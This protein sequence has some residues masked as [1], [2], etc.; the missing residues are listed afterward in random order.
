M[1]DTTLWNDTIV[2]FVQ[3]AAMS[4]PPPLTGLRVLEFA[5]LAPGRLRP[6]VYTTTPADRGNP[7]DHSQASY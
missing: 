1:V 4:Q 6:S 7:Q 5:G 3:S 2:S